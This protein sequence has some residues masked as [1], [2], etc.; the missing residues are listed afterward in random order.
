M[1]KSPRCH[2]SDRRG[3]AL[4]FIVMI[5]AVVAVAAAAL[6]DIVEVDILIAGEAR[7]SVL[8]ESIAIGGIKEVQA[9]AD[10][11]GLLPT[12]MTPNLELR[13]SGI[14]A[15]GNFERDP[16]GVAGGPVTLNE[17]NS[18]FVRYNTPAQDTLREGYSADIRL[19]RYGPVIN[20]GL[21]TTQAIIYEVRSQGSVAGGAA[22]SRVI[23]ETFNFG[24][25]QAGTVGQVHAR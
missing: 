19:V 9:D 10:K 11:I 5:V 25:V 4:L 2:R 21:N 14:A 1:M 23:A 6:L 22:S 16:D 3:F 12:P 24:A 18:A 7:R 13:Y 20:S 17:T 15:G 8:A